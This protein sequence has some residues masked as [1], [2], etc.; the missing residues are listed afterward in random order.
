MTSGIQSPRQA[1][2]RR[3]WVGWL[4]VV[5]A[6]V[7]AAFYLAGPASGPR[8]DS[9]AAGENSAVLGATSPDARPAAAAALPSNPE[10]VSPAAKLHRFALSAADAKDTQGAPDI[11]VG[12][13]RVHMAWAS[14]T[15]ESEQTCFFASSIE[16]LEGFSIP[17]T[18]VR[19]PIAYRPSGGGKKGFPIRMA[20]HVVA[21]GQS[22]YLSWSET[23]P[24]E[25]TVRMV[26][27]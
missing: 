3:T 12:D 4:F 17:R 19:S 20:P 18:V 27:V 16:G 24:D 23:V 22:V 6:S 1:V 25:T 15:G 21:Q 7:A 26:L 9:H 8:R 14:I 2:A 5:A 10:R 13:G 11:A